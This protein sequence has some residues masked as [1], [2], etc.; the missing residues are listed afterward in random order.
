MAIQTVQHIADVSFKDHFLQAEEGAPANGK[1]TVNHNTFD[2]TFDNGVVSAKFASGNAFSN[3]FRS[4][5]L[6]RFTQTLQAQYDSW[7]DQQARI[8]AAREAELAQTLGF[9]D[10]PDA[11]KVAGVVGEFKAVL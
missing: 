5:T 3:L 8:E 11:P 2:V 6:L 4:G 7:I 9:A 10:N 1:I